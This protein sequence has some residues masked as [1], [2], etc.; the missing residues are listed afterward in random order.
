M[1]ET[2][3]LLKQAQQMKNHFRV[4]SELGEFLIGVQ[5]LEGEV[6]GMRAQREA[7]RDEIE[8]LEN[9][10]TKIATDLAIASKDAA[11]RMEV[12]EKKNL[13]T[14]QAHKKK[15]EVVKKKLG[16][17]ILDLETKLTN[18]E[19]AH[20]TRVAEL[21]EEE[22]VLLQNIKTASI[23]ENRFKARVNAL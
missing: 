9:N 15:L 23:A 8:D 12:A 1:T 19:S 16:E 21:K 5:R 11:E 18:L 13:K 17:D 4:F 20:T 14:E 10:K 6:V 22:A 2:S 7:L 3:T